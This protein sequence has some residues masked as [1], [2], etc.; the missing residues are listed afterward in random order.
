MKSSVNIIEACD[1]LMNNDVV[2]S[3]FFTEEVYHKSSGKILKNIDHCQFELDKECN[4]K[5]KISK[6]EKKILIKSS[7]KM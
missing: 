6:F 1:V 3:I 7:K 5:T 2:I 4:F